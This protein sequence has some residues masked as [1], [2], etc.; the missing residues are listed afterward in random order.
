[1]TGLVVLGLAALGA[2]YGAW[3]SL[4]NRKPLWAAAT[5]ASLF[6]A[7][8]LAAVLVFWIAGDGVVLP[9]VQLSPGLRAFYYA[10]R[11]WGLLP[12]VSR[13]L[14][15]A[16]PLA[17]LILVMARRDRPS[18]L[19]P[20]PATVIFAWLLLAVPDAPAA[21]VR[22][23]G[24][25]QVAYLTI[26]PREEGTRVII[27]AGAPFATFLKIVH[28][29]EVETV[30]VELHLQWT[31]DG[32]ALVIRLHEQK[33]PCFAVDLDGHVTGGL[34]AAKREWPGDYVPGDVDQRFSLYRKEVFKLIQAH[35]GLAAP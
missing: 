32:K 35:G 21:V 16:A 24:P 12:S 13:W 10:E 22:A 15:L 3:S 4:R 25:E 17:H 30:P 29:H 28:V 27:G 33:D 34:P 6:A 19:V 31:R 5:A 11:D 23:R 1:M 8:G 18:L 2:A 14:L 9:G 7:A 20:L 26:A